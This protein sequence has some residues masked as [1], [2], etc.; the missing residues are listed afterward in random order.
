MG[1]INEQHIRVK[2]KPLI[3][4]VND[5]KKNTTTPEIK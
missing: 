4:E 3:A 5:S 1:K 2:T